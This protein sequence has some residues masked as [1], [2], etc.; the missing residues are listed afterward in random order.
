MPPGQLSIQNETHKPVEKD[1]K[2][3]PS[4]SAL[5]FK[6]HICQNPP[7]IGV[8]HYKGDDVY[9]NF[10]YYKIEGKWVDPESEGCLFNA[11]MNHTGEYD[12]ELDLPNFKRSETMGPRVMTLEEQDTFYKEYVEDVTDDID[13]EGDPRWLRIDGPTFARWAAGATIGD[14]Y[15]EDVFEPPAR[16]THA[17]VFYLS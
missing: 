9:A 16:F 2:I 15:E 4:P 3:G 14:R 5:S 1:E 7:S 12:E 17:C 6:E 11:Y 10:G 8:N 13:G